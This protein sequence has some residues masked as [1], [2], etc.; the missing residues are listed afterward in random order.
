MKKKEKGKERKRKKSAA[1]KEKEEGNVREEEAF[2]R[3]KSRERG[4]YDRVDQSFDCSMR[5]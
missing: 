1:R 4:G 3:W 2:Q 5:L